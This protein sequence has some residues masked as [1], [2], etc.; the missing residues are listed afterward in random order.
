VK[1]AA[2]RRASSFLSRDFLWP[3]P[4]Q[5]A[6]AASVEMCGGMKSKMPVQPVAI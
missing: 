1:F 3:P 6:A 2:M 5:R 4:D